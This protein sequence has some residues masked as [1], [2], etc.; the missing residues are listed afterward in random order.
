VAAR[1]TR[2]IAAKKILKKR[3]K[4]EAKNTSMNLIIAAVIAA[5]VSG[6]ILWITFAILWR[7][8]RRIGRAVSANAQIFGATL[9]S[10]LVSLGVVALIL[11]RAISAV[12]EAPVRLIISLVYAVFVNLT[13]VWA[14]SSLGTENAVT[15]DRTLGIV[16]DILQKMLYDLL[17]FSNTFLGQLS[18]ASV[19]LALALWVV[20]GQLLD[21]V[22]ET[23]PQGQLGKGKLIGFFERLPKSTRQN[24]LLAVVFL[25]SAYLSIAAMVAIPWLKEGQGAADFSQEKRQ[26]LQEALGTEEKF[27]QSFGGDYAVDP[28]AVLADST[29]PQPQGG[30][31]NDTL[32][33][34]WE[35]L[36]LETKQVRDNNIAQR[37]PILARWETFRQEVWSRKEKLMQAAVSGFESK[38][39]AMGIQEQDFYFREVYTWYRDNLDD[40]D[41]RLSKVQFFVIARDGIWKS[42]AENVKTSLEAALKQ[43]QAPQVSLAELPYIKVYGLYSS[44]DALGTA[45]FDAPEVFALPAMDVLPQPPKP[46]SQW[47]IFGFIA[48]W[49]LKTRAL[50]LVLITGMLGFGLFGAAISSV[51]REQVTRAPGEPLVKD[52]ASVV[53]RGLSAAVVVFLAV[54]GGVAIFTTSDPQPN[55]Y[56]LFFTCLVGAVFSERVWDWAR[57]RLNQN[58]A[59]GAA[60]AEN[61]PKSEEGS[62]SEPAQK[63]PEETQKPEQNDTQKKV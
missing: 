32:T 5:L 22:L 33:T 43:L 3:W 6:L 49:L 26:Q 12:I 56:V 16:L 45:L 40:L 29:L 55:P 37:Q 38:K 1:S 41:R 14:P 23:A 51:V 62:D 54:E 63:K 10:R 13:R 47:G 60:T 50:S 9:S 19:V 2:F 27:K 15:W 35:N 59:G 28:F 7:V 30:F 42:W 46:G 48:G 57:E 34:H 18:L 11:P 58:L 17:Q 20:A 53:V 21:L 25:V 39:N 24:L 44:E 52:L 61:A 31:A 4:R 36:L 8:F